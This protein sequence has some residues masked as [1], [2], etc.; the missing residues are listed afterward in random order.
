MPKIRKLWQIKPPNA[1]L[2]QELSDSLGISDV[3]AQVLINRGIMDQDTAKEFLFGG[4]ENLGD[5]YLL[6]DM[7]KAVSRIV[8]AISNKQK[9]IVYGDY[10]VDGITASALMVKV[11]K[12]LG[13]LIDYYI[14][15][16]Q[17]EGYGLN[18]AALNI[19]I[20]SGTKLLITVDCGISAVEEISHIHNQLDII[21]TDHHQPPDILPSA[22]AIINPKQKD[23]QYS[24]KNLAGVGVAFKLCQGLWQHYYGSN[25]TFLEY[26]DIVAIGTVADIVSLT[27]ENRIL[28]KL[29][30]SEL[31]NTKN[32]GLKEL[33]EVCGI[34]PSRID[35]G[36]IGFGIA[37]RLNAAGRISRADYGVELLITENI[38][39]AKELATHLEGENSQRQSVEKN[40]QVAAEVVLSEIDLNTEKVLVLVGEEWHS[41]VIGIVA[42]R[43]VD[44][45]FRPVVMISIRDG[46]GKASCRSIP[47]FDI[48]KALEQCSDLLLQFGGHRQAAGFSI[49]LENIDG[50][51][52]RLNHIAGKMLTQADYV[53]VL[54]IDSLVSLDEMS[55][56]FL[57]QLACLEP[58][59]MGN[60]SPIFV[61]KPLVLKEIRTMGQEARH[62]KLKVSQGRITNDVVA[63]QLGGLAEG[64]HNKENIE[65]AFFPEFNEWQGQRKIQ[66]RAYD[67]R[68]IE[69]ADFEKLYALNQNHQNSLE[70]CCV[71]NTS[72]NLNCE[73]LHKDNWKLEDF[74]NVGDKFKYILDIVRKQE[75]T[76]IVV[77]SSKKAF[78]LSKKLRIC[79][80]AY[81]DQI[82]VYHSGL[83]VESQTRVEVW[84]KESVFTV[85]VTTNIFI[86]RCLTTDI[87]HVVVYDM[88]INK[89]SLIHQCR[90]I[91]YNKMVSSIHLVF[92][93]K[94]VED[95]HL[96]LQ[97]IGPERI[98]V[99]QVYLV[100]KNSN[101]VVTDSQIA[102][103][104]L[105]KYQV[106]VSES[107]ISTAIKILEELDLVVCVNVENK[108]KIEI[109]PMPKQKLE[110]EKSHTFRQG[111]L[112]K[113][114]FMN[115]SKEIM[116][117]SINEL[118]LMI[119]A[120]Q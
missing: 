4:V 88:P 44:R 13:A 8:E 25:S 61:C 72:T 46:I 30:L 62:L 96:L 119:N 81:I 48:Y 52:V 54:K 1:S 47:A 107:S 75:K 39:R 93:N 80:P 2:K 21:I 66:L 98:V 31:A 97:Q 113:E 24:E 19:L 108:R 49:L 115:F 22:Y 11:L 86:E 117:L 40:I 90:L 71:I 26:L 70:D 104:I 111:M 18:S 106:I 12:E 5:P 56:N 57:E 116:T 69:I 28:V 33:M 65:V 37:P 6:K 79:L 77:N 63:W 45:Y 120:F 3:I 36:K 109:L 7:D 43:L 110:I 73:Y 99:G 50:L 10:D 58:Y 118:L 76:V 51:K 114:E 27:G 17:C 100:V 89:Q 95:T 94:D 78:E 20:D 85:L 34:G 103:Q 67:V 112:Q 35:T 101:D 84:F 64:L 68:K 60:H 41:G 55:T 32:I 59:G 9:V 105:R 16:R 53:P 74:R 83:D 91:G 14:P 15:E 38:Q 23:C 42:S 29:G 87:R 82:G 102:S 92:S